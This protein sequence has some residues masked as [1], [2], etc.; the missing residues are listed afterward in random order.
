MRKSKLF[1]KRELEILEERL[2]GSKED[3]TGLWSRK[4][5]P[6]VDELLSWFD[7]RKELKKVVGKEK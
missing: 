2:K 6:K 5:R 4:I 3:P 7:R 1:G